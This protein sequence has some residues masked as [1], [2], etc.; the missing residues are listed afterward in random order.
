MHSLS[1]RSL[2]LIADQLPNLTRLEL[3]GGE[4]VTPKQVVQSIA[5]FTRLK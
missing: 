1:I 4:R 3:H 5:R 2:S